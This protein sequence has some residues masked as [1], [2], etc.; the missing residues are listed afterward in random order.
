MT[1]LIQIIWR[2]S[3]FPRMPLIT[4]HLHTNANHTNQ[5]EVQHDKAP[6]DNP[7]I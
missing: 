4:S 1:R 7:R 5:N 3:I 2:K 6:T